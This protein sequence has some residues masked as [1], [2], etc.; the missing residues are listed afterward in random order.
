[1][2]KK[3]NTN[4]KVDKWIYVVFFGISLLLTALFV[5]KL[6]NDLWYLLSEGRYIVENGIY[7]YDPLSMHS[8]FAIVVQNWLSAVLFWIIF[9]VFGKMGMYFFILICTFF[10]SLLLYKICMLIS[11]RNTV[12]SLFLMIATIVTL[13][14]HFI[15]SRPQMLSFITLLSLIYVLE[16][17]IK[18]E[19]PKYLI[20]I[21][22]ISLIQVN[23]HAS[24]WWMLFL[25]MLPYVIDS[26]K[27]PILNTQGYK[28]KPL[29]LA[30][31]AAFLVGF[32]NPY[33]Y[34]AL[35]FIFTSY[36]DKYMHLFISELLPFNFSGSL[37]KHMF[38]IILAIGII[39]TLFREGHVRVRYICLFCG[40][41]ILGFM[42]VKGFSHFILVSFFPLAYFFKDMFP[43]VFE[44]SST[45]PKIFKIGTKVVGIL[46]IVGT[47]FVIATKNDRLDFSHD[48]ADALDVIEGRFSKK[49]STIYSSFNNGGYVEFRGW[50]PYIDPRAEAFLKVNNKEA[51]VFEEFYNLQHGLL[52]LGT[53]L[54]N[55][56]F[57]HL[58]VDSGDY[59]YNRITDDINYFIIYEDSK[60]GYR[61]FA[62]NDLYSYSER[63][64]II[65]NYNN[66]V[67]DAKQEAENKTK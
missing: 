57:T 48:A 64:E 40:T 62:R 52:D 15:V 49:T 25:F 29:F 18:K 60:K 27:M 8:S 37:S 10:I 43:N 30:I 24:L 36:G 46:L 61:L 34:K 12:L 44:D 20:W 67:N 33:G 2:A 21:P 65:N 19:N 14:S 59:M 58:L 7:H 5:R 54:K 56:N 23:M 9:D 55:Y 63:Q 45:F 11:E 17:Y 1:M 38:I 42:S 26:F 35:T 22:I 32:I 31:A 6:D 51:D 41:M 50:K 39:Y 13:L 16:L 53:F 4:K 66:A 47:A 28:K 3:K